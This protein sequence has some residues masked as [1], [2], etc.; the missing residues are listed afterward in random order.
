MKIMRIAALSAAVVSSGCATEM[1]WQRV[2]GQPVDRGFRYA[3][4]E[5]RGRAQHHEEEAVEAM[6]RCMYRRGYVWTAVYGDN[7]YNGYYSGNG[8]R[9]GHRGNGYY[10]GNGNDYDD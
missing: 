2:D 8:Y 4:A 3:A 7:G 10:N 6:K 5:C 9:S 1:A